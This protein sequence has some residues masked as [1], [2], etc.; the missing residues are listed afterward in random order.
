MILWKLILNNISTI[1]KID[2]EI[3]L[4]HFRDKYFEIQMEWT[5][6]KRNGCQVRNK[7]K[8]KEGNLYQEKKEKRGTPVIYIYKL[9]LYSIGQMHRDTRAA[10]DHGPGGQHSQLRRGGHLRRS[11]CAHQGTH[12]SQ[13]KHEHFFSSHLMLLWYCVH[14][15]LKT[16]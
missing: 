15:I 9:P 16:K 4:S 12:D 1:T 2:K 8:Q 10:D 7:K 13:F 11:R 14:S 3:I 5:T 6:G